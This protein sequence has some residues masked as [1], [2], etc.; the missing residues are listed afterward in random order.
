LEPPGSL[1]IF[2]E[3]LAWSET[4]ASCIKLHNILQSQDFVTALPGIK[5]MENGRFLA[6]PCSQAR[7]FQRKADL[8]LQDRVSKR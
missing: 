2:K 8:D 1:Q 6:H 5:A 7:R 3:R 4:S